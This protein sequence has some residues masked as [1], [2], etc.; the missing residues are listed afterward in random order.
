MVAVLHTQN[1]AL[2]LEGLL[3]LDRPV[4]GP[5]NVNHL[6]SRET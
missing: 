6:V 5:N 1:S 2:W 3:V 4:D